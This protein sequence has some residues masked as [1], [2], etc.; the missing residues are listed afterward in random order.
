MT[1]TIGNAVEKLLK[2]FQIEKP[3]KQRQALFIW[4]EI[5]GEAIARHTQA[6]DV[7]YDKLFIKVDSPV[8]RNELIFRREDILNMINRRLGNVKIKEIVLR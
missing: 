3:V 7:K 1:V 6:E 5:V 2:K 4:D 8:W